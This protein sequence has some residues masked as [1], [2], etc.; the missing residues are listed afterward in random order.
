MK[1]FHF[2]EDSLVDINLKLNIT[3]RT[4]NSLTLSWE[5]I[6]HADGFNVVCT[7]PIKGQYPNSIQSF[8]VSNGDKLIKLTSK[9]YFIINIKLFCV[10]IYFAFS[11]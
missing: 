4:E 7:A 1:R 6:E 3:G 2:D 9:Y 11:F 8:N 10:M 5:G